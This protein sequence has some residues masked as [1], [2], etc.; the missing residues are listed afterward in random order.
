LIPELF[1]LVPPALVL[2]IL[3]PV[4]DSRPPPIRK[5]ALAA[6]HYNQRISNPRKR[7]LSGA[8]ANGTAHLFHFKRILC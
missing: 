5:L 4:Q 3:G 8:L 7:N 1:Q 6:A 2:E